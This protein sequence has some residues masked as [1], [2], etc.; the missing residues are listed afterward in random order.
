M[1]IAD[2]VEQIAAEIRTDYHDRAEWLKGRALDLRSLDELEQAKA[3]EAL[4]GVVHGMGGLLDLQVEP[5]ARQR[6]DQLL[7]ELWSRIAPTS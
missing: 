6:L 3:V 4:R 5:A 2:L 1:P 7:D